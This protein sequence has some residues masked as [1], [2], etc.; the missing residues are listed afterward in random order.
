MAGS[1][2]SRLCGS[3]DIYEHSGKAPVHS[4]NFVTCHDG[5]TLKDLVSYECKHNVANGEDS[6]DGCNNNNS[7]NYGI[8]GETDDPL[9]QQIRLRQMKNLIVTLFMAR[10]VPM[11]LGGDEFRRS[12]IGNNNAYCQDNATSWFDW[13]LVS[14]NADFVRFVKEM[15]LLRRRFPVLSSARFYRPDE[16]DWFNPEGHAPDWGN[17][18]ALGGLIHS[19][20]DGQKLCLLANPLAES[21]VFRI[22]EPPKGRRWR[23]LVDTAISAPYDIS[24][25]EDAVPVL[26]EGGILIRERSLILLL[27]GGAH[28]QRS[29]Q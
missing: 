28:E 12:Q 4:I 27:A 29:V 17:D 9:I 2:A 7:C 15:I 21:R 6:R 13:S 26:S 8:E 23:R 3:A 10:G 1:F 19:H 11:L 22:P 16:I 14:Q 5:F 18:L 24:R 25:P 20:D